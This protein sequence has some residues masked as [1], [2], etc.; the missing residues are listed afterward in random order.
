MNKKVLKIFIVVSAMTL[1]LLLLPGCNNGEQSTPDG[2][3]V[4]GVDTDPDPDLVDTDPEKEK[5]YLLCIP[6][7]LRCQE[8]SDEYLEKCNSSGDRWVLYKRCALDEYCDDAVC[9]PRETDGDDDVVEET[10]ESEDLED[11]FEID[12]ET[13]EQ[14]EELSPECIC[15]GHPEMARVVDPDTGEE[16]CIDKYEATVFENPD[17][18]GRVYGQDFNE[19]PSDFPRCIGCEEGIFAD[20]ID[21]TFCD[22]EE[23][24]GNIN[25]DLYACSIPQ[26]APSSST[27]F[28]RAYYGCK[29]SGKTLC[30][31][32]QWHHSCT[33]EGHT[34]YPYGNERIPEA[35]NLK[36]YNPISAKDFCS[37]HE[38]GQSSQCVSNCLVC[39]LLGNWGEH[40]YIS[41]ENHMITEVFTVGGHFCNFSSDSPDLDTSC[42]ANAIFES[43]LKDRAVFRCCIDLH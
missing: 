33:N 31:Y 26:V 27:T 20:T 36:E 40:S 43:S 13:G 16:W 22:P 6:E 12:D 2:D 24:D 17:C 34:E 8:G 3:A 28:L 11:E 15:P 23:M 4:D 38:T 10:E 39:D 7:T 37:P 5:E 35:C 18:T 21:C 14:E 41:N 29:N 30:S 42:N 1:V 19:W 32:D 25:A 9:V